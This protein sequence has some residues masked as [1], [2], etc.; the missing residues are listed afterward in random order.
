MR[1]YVEDR[2]PT[3]VPDKLHQI[4]TRRNKVSAALNVSKFDSSLISWRLNAC[5]NTDHLGYRLKR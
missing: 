5:K 2:A 4:P 1:V 3:S